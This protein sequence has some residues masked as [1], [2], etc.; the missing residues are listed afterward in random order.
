MNLAFTDISNAFSNMVQQD[1]PKEIISGLKNWD[2]EKPQFAE[3]L[4]EV[5]EKI[6]NFEK[7]SSAF[8]SRSTV[9][10]PKVD[11][12]QNDSEKII[13]FLSEKLN[14]AKGTGFV[15]ALQNILYFE[16]I[17]PDTAMITAFLFFADLGSGQ[18][19][20]KT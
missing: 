8:T 1:N 4:S 13:N 19:F 3:K 17:I 10:N 6:E 12:V 5:V 15:A 7:S 20:T 2:S 9:A 14:K 16:G 18:P 11:S